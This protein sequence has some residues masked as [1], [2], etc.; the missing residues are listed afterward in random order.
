MKLNPD[1]IRDILLTVEQF[2]EYGD[3]IR[4]D[5]SD[6]FPLLEKYTPNEFLYHINQC[7]A[8]G[9]FMSCNISP[10]GDNTWIGNLSPKGHEFIS[11]IREEKIWKKVLKQATK[12][13]SASLPIIMKIA[14][15]TVLTFMQS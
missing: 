7:K 8:N 12:I 15:D 5:T 10:Q 11:N 3:I 9:F 1:C 14:S 2:S 4:Y 6:D 13:G